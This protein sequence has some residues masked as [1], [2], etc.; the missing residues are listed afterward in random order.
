MVFLV[1]VPGLR[2]EVVDPDAQNYR[3]WFQL[4]VTGS[5]GI[6]NWLREP[7]LFF[8]S[9]IVSG[10]S[11]TYTMV[12]VIYAL[13]SLTFYYYFMVLSVSN[14]WATFYFYLILCRFYLVQDFAQIRTG[15]A[16]P[17]MSISIALL[18]SG[19]R[20]QAIA[21]YLLALT[22]HWSVLIGLP[23]VVLLL[24]G[25]EFRSRIWVL[26][27]VP[28]TGVA[29]VALH[30]IVGY[31]SVIERLSRYYADSN[32]AEG[33]SALSLHFFI[34]FAVVVWISLSYWE[35]LSL[36][37]R[38]AT[39]CTSLGMFF[40]VTFVQLSAVAYRFEDI[41]DL[42]WVLLIIDL[43]EFSSGVKRIIYI[44]MLA[45]AGFGLFYVSLTDLRPYATV[46]FQ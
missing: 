5:I 15:V 36:L 17:L 39:V 29:L 10:L 25:V 4:A 19:K 22:F 13:L 43:L 34:H 46:L 26:F 33:L 28:L 42:F 9:S 18:C 21:L 11:M 45:F 16:I 35:R 44:M 7:A 23:I 38:V 24:L 3:D 40:F 30:V 1:L 20:K 32:A 41:F 31:L 27:F 2:S 8:I 12:Q 37:S 14:R 6:E